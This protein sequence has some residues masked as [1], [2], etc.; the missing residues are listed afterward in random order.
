MRYKYSDIYAA[1]IALIIFLQVLFPKQ[2]PIG[3]LLFVIVV[4][5]GIYSKRLR[6]NTHPVFIGF[7]LFYIA[8]IAGIFFTQD[9]QQSKV[10]IE[11]KLSFIIFPVLF[12]FRP[13]F[14]L[15]LRIPSVFLMIAVIMA[16]WV[17]FYQGILC[18]QRSKDLAHCFVSSNFSTIHHPTYFAMY[19]LAAGCFA[20]FGYFCKWR[21]FS[22]RNVVII[23]LYFLMIYLLTFSLSGFLFLIPLSM[24][25]LFVYGKRKWGGKKTML[26]VVVITG[27]LMTFPFLFGEFRAD[28]LKTSGSIVQYVKSPTSFLN[29]ADRRLSGNE[30]RLVMWTVSGEII[31]KYPFGVGTGNIDIYLEKQLN[32]YGLKELADKKYNPHNQFLQTWLE[33]GIIGLLILLYIFYQLI[34]SAY[35]RKNWVLMIVVTNLIFNSLFESVFQRQS[36][37]VFFT[38]IICLLLVYDA[39]DKYDLEADSQ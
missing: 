25:I 33:I 6:F 4:A 30:E 35:S 3:I 16:S 36:G 27:I 9:I 26:S 31:R 20:W 24:A 14:K 18:Y 11:N 15:S 19:I 39:T 8:Y 22:K 10:Y 34:K 28:I 1:S 21:F 37:I 13:D 23:T 7:I 32:Q 29:N 5:A 17:G 12:S 38:L 2:I